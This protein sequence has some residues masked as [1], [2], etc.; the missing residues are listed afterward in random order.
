MITF[1]KFL[2][3]ALSSFK[4]ASKIDDYINVYMLSL[5]MV[6]HLGVMGQDLIFLGHLQ[7]PF[8]S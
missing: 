5:T 1:G 6:Q 4:Q 3:S 7:S 2:A 8:N